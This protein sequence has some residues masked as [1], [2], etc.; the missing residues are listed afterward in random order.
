MST[1]FKKCDF[2]LLLLL[3]FRLCPKEVNYP[4]N[5]R[6]GKPMLMAT[7]F[8]NAVELNSPRRRDRFEIF[9]P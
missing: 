3:Q 8:L 7:A 1:T 6:K 5:A 2:I 9:H 4:T